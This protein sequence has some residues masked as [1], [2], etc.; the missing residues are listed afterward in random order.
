MKQSNTQQTQSSQGNAPSLSRRIESLLGPG[1]FNSEEDKKGDQYSW[2]N[3][4]G[5]G[6]G[7]RYLGFFMGGQ[8]EVA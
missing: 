2:R 7:L 5:N 1:L 8:G 3:S 4:K 6:Q